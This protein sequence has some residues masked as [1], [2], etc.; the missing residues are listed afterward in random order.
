M[1]RSNLVEKSKM[2]M[3]DSMNQ[4]NY[5]S[6]LAKAAKAHSEAL[7]DMWAA[8]DRW[9]EATRKRDK[10]RLLKAF[11]EARAI[12]AAAKKAYLSVGV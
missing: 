8:R 1:N 12:E 2:G 6:P 9:I 10:E 3:E 7:S 11:E 5:D 4:I